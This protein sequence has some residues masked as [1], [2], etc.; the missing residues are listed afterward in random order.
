M[1]IVTAGQVRPALCPVWGVE[2]EALRLV[3][4]KLM[5][6]RIPKPPS[7]ARSI[8]RS[9]PTKKQAALTEIT[10]PACAGNILTHHVLP[11]LYAV[12]P[13]VCGEHGTGRPSG[14]PRGGS[15][16]RVRGTLWL[17]VADIIDLCR[18]LKI[19]RMF[20][21]SKTSKSVFSPVRHW[22]KNRH[23]GA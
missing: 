5:F 12:H 21:C 15:S 10:H 23:N 11:R 14:V 7:P 8:V 20:Y 6:A 1:W 13:R 19:Y 22:P 18:P 4:R 16:P 17:E 2:V 9:P 3:L